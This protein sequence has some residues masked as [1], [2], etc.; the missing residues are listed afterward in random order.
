M[1]PEETILVVDHDGFRRLARQL[2]E[3]AGFTVAE[4]AN[5]ADATET[6]RLLRPRIALQTAV[7][8]QSAKVCSANFSGSLVSVHTPES[9]PTIG[10]PPPFRCVVVSWSLMISSSPWAK[11]LGLE[12]GTGMRPGSLVPLLMSK[13]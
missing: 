13:A 8:T 2:I 1:V 9:Y 3:A 7:T 11:A 5:G 12:P 6:A 4:A 10:Y